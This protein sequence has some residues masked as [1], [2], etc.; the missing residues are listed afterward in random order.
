MAGPKARIKVTVKDLEILF[1]YGYWANR[2]IFDVIVKL[3][4]EQ[5]TQSSP[6]A[7]DPSETR[8]F[9]S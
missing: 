3:P 1:D 6:E 7:M 4:A 9:M 8:W 5:F 2:R